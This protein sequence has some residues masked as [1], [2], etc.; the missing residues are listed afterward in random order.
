MKNIRHRIAH[1]FGWNLGSVVSWWGDDK[2]AYIGFQCAT[3]GEVTGER[4]RGWPWKRDRS[5]STSP[6]TR[7]EIVRDEE[8]H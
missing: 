2:C 7:N 4:M 1:W 3:C 6:I 5:D 8:Q